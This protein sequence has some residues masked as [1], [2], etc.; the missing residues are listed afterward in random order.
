VSDPNGGRGLDHLIEQNATELAFLD[1]YGARDEAPELV[2]E[3]IARRL[4]RL[5]ARVS[6]R[7]VRACGLHVV[8]KSDGCHLTWASAR[9]PLVPSDLEQPG[10]REG[11]LNKERNN[12]N[13]VVV[14]WTH[15]VR[16]FFDRAVEHEG[17]GSA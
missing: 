14:G 9:L 15:E 17:S 13:V 4:R 12:A 7:E 2:L 5:D 16:R 8:A 11:R 6:E 10:M 1:A 3:E